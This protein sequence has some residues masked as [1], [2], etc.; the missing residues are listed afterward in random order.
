MAPRS[1]SRILIV[2]A[3]AVGQVYGHHLAEAGCS[4]SV[5]VKPKYEEAAKE[6]YIL[7]HHSL[8]RSTV[9][10]FK[11][12]NVFTDV[13]K[14]RGIWHEIWLCV[15][16]PAI[17]E[18]WF[19]D[20]VR[21]MVGESTIVAF[22]PGLD[23]HDYLCARLGADRVVQGLIGMISYQAPLPGEHLQPGV[24]YYFPPLAPSS[25]GGPADR[26]TPVVELLQKGGCPAA[27]SEDAYEQQALGSSILNPMIVGLEIED[28]SFDQ[29]AS[30]S[31]LALAVDA[32]T[33]A[34]GIV[35]AKT[36]A[37][38][39]LLNKVRKPWVF[40]LAMPLARW[41]MPFPLETYLRYH[42]S[43]VR[44]QTA[45]NVT[46]YLE[47]GGKLRVPIVSIRRLHDKWNRT[48]DVTPGTQMADIHHSAAS[49]AALAAA[50]AAA[51]VSAS[52]A[53]VNVPILEAP[54]IDDVVLDAPIVEDDIATKPKVQLLP[55]GTAPAVL[56][57][58]P[59]KIAIVT[60]EDLVSL[61][62]ETPIPED[63]E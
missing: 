33:E 27:L 4:V 34:A 8:R 16:T 55:A 6:G 57:T 49:S 45:R 40:K 38:S 26:A 19:D 17:Y 62:E 32:A 50:P 63:D 5:L 28:W 9:K 31:T 58:N 3:G 25:V 51:S 21:H 54:I 53:A 29:F 2:G 14:A 35:E 44:T 61:D 18:P 22:Q 24:A 39:W 56:V 52:F 1:D 7:H 59:E 11:P 42:F 60:D 41:L 13:S 43:K 37:K 46:Q 23:E 12:D 20:F 48:L 15:P 36:R 47:Y 30:S 10:K